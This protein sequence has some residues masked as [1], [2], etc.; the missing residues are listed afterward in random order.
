MGVKPK[1]DNPEVFTRWMADYLTSKGH[2]P[3]PPAPITVSQPL[4]ISTF[5]GEPGKGEVSYDVWR[6]EVDR[7]LKGGQ[8]SSSVIKDAVIRSLKG[9]ASNIMLCLSPDST[10]EE[11]MSKVC[12]IYGTVQEK[13]SLVGAF[14]SAK[15]KEGE[16][17]REW[18]CRVEELYARAIVSGALHDS[19]EAL[20]SVFWEGLLQPLKDAS[21]H[22]FDSIKSFDKLRAEMR[23]IDESR[24][25]M[26]NTDTH[27]V[28]LTAKVAT[29][30]E[31]TELV[32]IVK[33]LAAEVKSL[34]EYVSTSQ[35]YTNRSRGRGSRGRD[36]G[37]G[38]SHDT[39]TGTEVVDDDQS[40]ECYRCGQQGHVQYGCRVR[41]DHCRGRGLNRRGFTRRG[42]P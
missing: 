11:I 41:L 29:A 22:K 34:R 25:S 38:T 5:M 31:S 39:D 28:K 16:S 42:R 19:Q 12:S 35:N 2:I 37:R 10:V 40:V 3:N 9:K 33:Q 1:A 27:K 17:V 24:P 20:C 14:Y 32:G 6:Y 18:G 23:R 4:K 7:L 8:Y 26:S 30:S 21:G 13:T 15:Q 36:R